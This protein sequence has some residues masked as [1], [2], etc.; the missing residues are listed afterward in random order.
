MF[1]QMYIYIHTMKYTNRKWYADTDMQAADLKVAID[2]EIREQIDSLVDD[3]VRSVSEMQR[4]VCHEV[5]LLFNNKTAPLPKPTNRRFYPSRADLAGLMYRRRRA[6]LQG[7]MDQDVLEDKVSSFSR[8][9]PDELWVFR[10]STG[11]GT[12]TLLLVHQNAFQKR[13]LVR[14]GNELTFVDATYRT[15]RYAVPLFFVC[16][17]TNDGYVVVAFTVTEKEDS[18]SLA[19]A[20]G[21]LKAANADWQPQ[22]FMLDSSEMEMSAI[23]KIFPGEL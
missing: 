13:L 12:Q 14:Y 17:H 10:R 3:G 5:K 6:T 1:L 7:R 15:T 16:V 9:K 23:R 19:E 8:D 11:D 21:Y 20:L 4:H 18:E 2:R 22:G